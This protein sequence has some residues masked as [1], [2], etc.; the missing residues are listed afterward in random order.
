M[1]KSLI[2]EMASQGSDAATAIFKWN[3]F[4]AI[5]RFRKLKM[6]QYK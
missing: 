1:Q 6:A 4:N 5:T 2:F 3:S